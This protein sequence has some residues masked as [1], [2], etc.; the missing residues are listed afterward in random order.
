MGEALRWSRHVL[1]RRE[2]QL[3]GIQSSTL[4][5]LPSQSVPGDR[6]VSLIEAEKQLANWELSLGLMERSILRLTRQ[7][8]HQEEIGMALNRSQQF[9]SKTLNR[10]NGEAVDLVEGH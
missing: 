1:S 7:G 4:E 8:L 2:V 3:H 10:L 6:F 5:Q 9:I